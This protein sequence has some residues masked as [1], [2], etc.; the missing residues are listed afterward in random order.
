MNE[1]FSFGY[2]NSNRT[3]YNEIEK[4]A[5]ASY[6]EFDLKDESYDSRIISYW[7]KSKTDLSLNEDELINRVHN[8]IRHAVK[9][10]LISDLPVGAFLSGGIDSSLICAIYREVSNTNINTYSIGFENKNFDET[11]FANSIANKLGT[12]HRTYIINDIDVKTLVP[13]IVNF[14]DEPFFDASQIPT[15]IVSKLAKN[16]VTVILSGDGGDELFCGYTR[17]F[18]A[19]GLEK[20][21]GLILRKKLFRKCAIFLI[22]KGI[23]KSIFE[24]FPKRLKPSNLDGKIEK[25]ISLLSNYNSGSLYANMMKVNSDFTFL[26]QSFQELVAQ[27]PLQHGLTDE[28]DLKRQYMNHDVANYLPNDIL[29]KVDI[30]SMSVSLE[31]RV[32]FLTKGMA[33][34]AMSIPTSL[35]TNYGRTGKYILK[36]I[37]ARYIGWELIERPKMGFGVPMADWLR[38]PLRDWTEE[39]INNLDEGIFSK[40]KVKNLYL[41]HSNGTHDHSNKIWSIIIFQ[42]WLNN[43]NLSHADIV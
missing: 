7:E 32:P 20:K 3:I 9:S 26:Q 33:E 6:I 16:D 25:L 27:C 15:Q 36:S 21:L 37:L 30:A 38:H 28:A 41:E 11:K 14:W 8:Q 17:Y 13:N 29:K 35:H 23:V 34:M 40:E 31:A 5:P 39:I 1:Y 10:C 18:V 12:N 22:E 24:K 42:N 19:E 43:R 2:I 4:V